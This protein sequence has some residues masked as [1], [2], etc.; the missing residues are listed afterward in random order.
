MPMETFSKIIHI[1]VQGL[2]SRYQDFI[3]SH[4]CHVGS[5][6]AGNVIMQLC[7]NGW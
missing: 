3:G 2:L 1:K 7:V 5:N 4:L 6:P